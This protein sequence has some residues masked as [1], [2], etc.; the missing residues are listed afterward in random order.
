M[1]SRGALH[2]GLSQEWHGHMLTFRRIKEALGMA[3]RD[4]APFFTNPHGEPLDSSTAAKSVQRAMKAAGI[5]FNTTANTF[6]HSITTM[7]RS[8]VMLYHSSRLSCRLTSQNIA[9]PCC[10]RLTHT[11]PRSTRVDRISYT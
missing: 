6:R 7:V 11:N 4:S 3:L 9:L 10:N 8:R 2:L 5:P 1:R